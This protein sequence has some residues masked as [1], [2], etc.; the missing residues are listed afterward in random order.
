MNGEV[1]LERE[2]KE[3]QSENGTQEAES[4][5][6]LLGLDEF[7]ESNHELLT[8]LGI[9][10][11]VSVYLTQLPIELATTAR[12][13][14]AGSSILF[15]LTTFLVTWKAVTQGLLAVEENDISAV[16]YA[17]VAV[18]FLALIKSVWA[19]INKFSEGIVPALDFAVA[20]SFGLLYVT[21]IP[22]SEVFTE[23]EGQEKIQKVVQ[24][25]PKIAAGYI[26]LSL[27]ITETSDSP[28]FVNSFQNNTM[29]ESALTIILGHLTVTL[30]I[31][32]AGTVLD[33]VA[34]KAEEIQE[35]LE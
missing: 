29:T 5:N 12:T 18:C 1:D 32:G 7:I 17:I 22:S 14:I 15:V 20:V 35:T 8:I 27:L 31:L 28:F 11:A 16:I 2:E 9:F 13:G 4:D 6:E 30:F 26:G 24:N 34:Q 3:T 10:G 19:L 23:Y 25:A 33:K 21:S